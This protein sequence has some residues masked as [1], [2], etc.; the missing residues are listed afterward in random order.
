MAEE[1][2]EYEDSSRKMLPHQAELHQDRVNL[3]GGL[4]F[5]VADILVDLQRL[6]QVHIVGSAVDEKL[7][8]E[9]SSCDG[10]VTCECE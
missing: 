7:K 8:M 5:M 1:L 3:D 10:G 9:W 2:L 6:A 4:N